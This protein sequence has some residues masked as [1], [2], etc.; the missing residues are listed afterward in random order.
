MR[1]VFSLQK[2]GMS[3]A[4]LRR[5]NPRIP[6]G[7]RGAWFATIE[8]ARANGL[9]ARSA[10]SRRARIC[11]TDRRNVMPMN[12][13]VRSSPAWAAERRYRPNRRQGD[14]ATG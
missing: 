12:N 11:C 13:A 6:D 8:G 2:N 5:Q 9:G 3:A 4:A 1:T 10:R 14:G 7:A